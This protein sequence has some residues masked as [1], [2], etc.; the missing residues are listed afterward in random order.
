VRARE[1]DCIKVRGEIDP[2]FVERFDDR[3]EECVGDSL[4]RSYGDLQWHSP[5]VNRANPWYLLANT[6]SGTY[7]IGVLTQP[8][9]SADGRAMRVVVQ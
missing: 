9:R 5:S 3:V 2:A 1:S 7:A 8:G 4:E 6:E